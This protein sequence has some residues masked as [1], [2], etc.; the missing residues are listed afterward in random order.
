[1]CHPLTFKWNKELHY[2]AYWRWLSQEYMLTT[3]LKELGLHHKMLTLLSSL[4]SPSFHCW[5]ISGMPLAC[6]WEK[7]CSVTLKKLEVCLR[8][9]KFQFQMHIYNS[10][11]FPINILK[12]GWHPEIL[13]RLSSW[14]YKDGVNLVI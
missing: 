3:T 7:T 9:T 10:P 12:S 11:F 4:R 5:N 1:M 14:S 6:F 8:I 13:N 2:W